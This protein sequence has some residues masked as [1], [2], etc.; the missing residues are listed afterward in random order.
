MASNTQAHRQLDTELKAL[1]KY[2]HAYMQFNLPTV[3]TSTLLCRYRHPNLVDLMGFCVHAEQ[4]MTALVYEYL[5]DGS[6][7]HSLHKVIY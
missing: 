7:Y 2:M 1:T 6:L 3:I 5:P 4:Q